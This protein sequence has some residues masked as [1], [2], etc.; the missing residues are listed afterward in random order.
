[1]VVASPFGGMWRNVLAV[2]VSS[3]SDL[4]SMGYIP[5]ALLPQPPQELRELLK[6]SACP[7]VHG[8]RVVIIGP[9]CSGKSLIAP[10]IEAVG[11]LSSPH[12]PASLPHQSLRSCL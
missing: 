11:L 5:D 9:P 1:M 10:M 12:L 8:L 6:P 3:L 7:S 2:A 4:V